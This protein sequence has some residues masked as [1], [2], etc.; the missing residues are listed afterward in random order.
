MEVLGGARA[1]ATRARGRPAAVVEPKPVSQFNGVWR[2]V[3]C[4]FLAAG[5]GTGSRRRASRFK[6]KAAGASGE[7]N[8]AAAGTGL[9]ADMGPCEADSIGTHDRFGIG[10]DARGG[11]QSLKAPW[12]NAYAVVPWCNG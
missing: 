9:Y 11:A 8:G 5:W 4:R 6:R 2:T 12:R 1:D 3:E 10:A 7:A